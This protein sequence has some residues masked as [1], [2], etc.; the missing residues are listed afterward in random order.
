MW[1]KCRVCKTFPEYF[2]SVSLIYIIH[3]F[4]MCYPINVTELLYYV[5]SLVLYFSCQLLVAKYSPC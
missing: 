5:K 2:Y 1:G 3:E 4:V